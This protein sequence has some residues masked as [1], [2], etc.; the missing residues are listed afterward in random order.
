MP[1]NIS[2]ANVWTTLNQNRQYIA[3]VIDEFG[4]TAGLI[5]IEDLIEEIFGELQDEFDEEL[6]LIS[7]DKRGRIYLRGDLLV[8]DVNEYLNLNLPEEEADT[9]G[10]LILSEMGRLPETGNEVSIGAPGVLVQVE[11]M[12]GHTITEVSLQ[13]PDGFAPSGETVARIGEWEVGDHD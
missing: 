11:A 1:E 8:S 10:G 9:L 7:S 5:T 4:G 13:R 3:I 2:I 6:P 12:E